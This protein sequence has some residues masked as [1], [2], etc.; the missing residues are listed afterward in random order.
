MLKKNW[1]FIPIMPPDRALWLTLISLNYLVSNIFSW[2]QRCSSHWTSAALILEVLFTK[3]LIWNPLPNRSY[4]FPL[5]CCIIAPIQW[6]SYLYNN[7]YIS[8]TT[9][10]PWFLFYQMMV[11]NKIHYIKIYRYAETVNTVFLQL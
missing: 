5:W 3:L 2:F 10:F 11:N 8:F 9:W 1:K 6:G 4:A 7:Y